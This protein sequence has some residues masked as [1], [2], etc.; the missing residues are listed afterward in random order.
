MEQLISMEFFGKKKSKE[1]ITLF[2]FY[3]NDRNFL[4]HLFG[5]PVPGFM[6]REIEKFTGILLLIQ[7][8]PIPLFGAKNSTAVAASYVHVFLHL[9][10]VIALSANYRTQG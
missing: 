6:S 1:G 5:L 9:D 2:Q 4:Y 10:N 7:L 8:N 3:Q